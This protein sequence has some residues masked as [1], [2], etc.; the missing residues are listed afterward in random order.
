MDS[1]K[2]TGAMVRPTRAPV[3]S[4]TAMSGAIPSRLPLSMTMD[5]WGLALSTPMTRATTS[6]PSNAV[7]LAR[8]S[9]SDL[10]EAQPVLEEA[11]VLVEEEDL[12]LELLVLGPDAAEIEVA[13]PER[14]DAADRS[15]RGPLDGRKDEED[16]LLEE[17]FPGTEGHLD[18]DEQDVEERQ[19]DEDQGAS[20]FIPEGHATSRAA[21]A[22]SL[23]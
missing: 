15:G 6:E 13:V 7:R 3:R 4:Q 12:P 1:F 17:R 8:S 18:G 23:R 20:P 21:A 9:A 19:S 14:P 10:E 22:R 16:G 11:D 2:L 5:W